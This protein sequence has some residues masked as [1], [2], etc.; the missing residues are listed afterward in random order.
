[1]SDKKNRLMILGFDGTSPDLL[2]RWMEEGHLPSIKK[3]VEDGAYGHLESVPNTCS[4]CAWTTFATGKNAGK[5]GIYRF[6]ERDFG[7]YRYNFVNGAHRRAKAFW[8]MLCGD[9]VGCVVNVPMTYPAEEI[10]GCWVSGFD[11]PGVESKGFCYPEGLLDE[12]KAHNGP[13]RIMRDF[14]SLLR[15]DADWGKTAEFLLDSLESRYRHTVYLMDKYDWELFTVVFMETDH[16][17]HFFWKFLDPKH[18]DYRP[19]DAERFGDTILNVYKSM[20]DIVRRLVEKNPDATVMIVSDHGGAVNTRGGSLVADWLEG[21]N[22]LSRKDAGGGGGRG[23]LKKIS[24]A[25]MRKAFGLVNRHLSTEA[26]FRL[27]RL[28]PGVRA[29]VESAVRLG[30][31]DWE[32]TKA[33]CDGAQDDIWI[34][35][36]DRDPLGVVSPEE[37]DELC[38][39]I[40]DELNSAVDAKTGRPVVDAAFRRRDVYE[41]G[42]VE[43]SPD[44]SIRWKIDGVVTGIRSKSSPADIT[45]IDWDW[46][47]DIPNGGHRIEGVVVAHG[48]HVAPGVRLQGAQLQD[49]APTV[50]Y[51]FDE[52]IP[53]DMDGRVIGE[54]FKGEY[55]RA[56]PPR[57]GAAAGS[58]EEQ[59]EDIYSE[60][61]ASVIEQRLKDLGYI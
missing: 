48:P 32:K 21:L 39:F 18:P 12:M 19:E 35:L 51:H 4:P 45:P 60:E 14:G 47:A 22:L 33:Y 46:P 41:G 56:R 50:L 49:I 6:T 36:K 30:D 17:H 54:M 10:N 7:S 57:G 61:D 11:A 15:K 20:D 58:M 52:E 2:E 9:R 16:A 43:R 59:Q 5:H 40:C 42:Y 55:F 44:I 8:N 34:N 25:V 28:M 1:M 38:D 53:E 37:Y 26:K 3:L 24:T 23:T 29:K 27:I 13:Y 31:I